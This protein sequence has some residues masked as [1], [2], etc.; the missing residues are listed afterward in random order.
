MIKGLDK[1]KKL[2][3]TLETMPKT[4]AEATDKAMVANSDE[5][6]D[7][8]VSQIKTGRDG[9]DGALQYKKKRKG[10]L[11]PSNSYTK[12]YDRFKS[13]KG[14]Q[15]GHVD[16]NLSGNYL[17]SLKLEQIGKGRFRVNSDEGFGGYYGNFSL[18]EEL[19]YNYSKD[20]HK[21]TDGAMSRIINY[22]IVP[23]VEIRIQ[24]QL[25]KI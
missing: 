6:V 17:R 11:N 9:N 14:G 13:K 21:I 15:T 12:A 10:E 4:A 5:F 16:L 2:I 8:N 19:E 20:I 22:E 24:N 18:Q 1:L 7:A 23:D 3:K 25:N